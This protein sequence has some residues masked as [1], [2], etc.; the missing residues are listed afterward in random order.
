MIREGKGAQR[1]LAQQKRRKFNRKIRSLSRKSEIKALDYGFS[2]G[3]YMLPLF[4]AITGM[5]GSIV[6]D[7]TGAGYGMMCVN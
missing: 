1:R 5:D 7:N 6:S 4:T 2:G 3:T